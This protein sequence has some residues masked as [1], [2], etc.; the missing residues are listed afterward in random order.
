MM[1]A[2][3]LIFLIHFLFSGIPGP[4]IPEESSALPIEEYPQGYFSFP[5]SPGVTTSLSGSFGDIRINHFHAGLDI[6][7][8]GQEGKSIYSAGPGYVSRIKVSTGGYGNAL[9][10][11][12]PNG[13]TTVYGHLKEYAHE[14][15][16]YL[17][18]RQYDKQTWEIDLELKPDEIPVKKGELVAIS[19]NTG[20][21]GGPHLH[22]E[23]RD[24]EENTLDPALFGFKEI[25]DNVAPA[26]EYIS[27]KCM[28]DDARINGQ[29]GDFDFP[30]V[31][32]AEGNYSLPKELQLWGDIGLEIYT[33]DK[34]QTSPFKLGIKKLEIQ[35]NEL[36]T[37]YYHL[38]KLA[39]HNKIDCNLHTNYRRMVESNDKLHKGYFETGNSMELYEYDRNLGVLNCREAGESTLINIKLSDSYNNER[40]VN[41]RFQVK[42]EQSGAVPNLL[43]K[44]D[45]YKVFLFDTQL[46][47]I[48]LKQNG[49][50]VLWNTQG[51]KQV[52]PAYSNAREETFVFDL[53]SGFF[54]HFLH[55]GAKVKLPVTHRI[56]P[57]EREINENAYEIDF[58]N[59][60]F[61]P[62]FVNIENTGRKLILDKDDKPL[63]ESFYV[64]WKPQ[65]GGI[66]EEKDKVYNVA[67]K[68][69]KY[70]GGTWKGDHVTFRPKEFG[71]YE[72]LRDETPPT[73]EIRKISASELVF[74][75]SDTLSGIASFECLVNGEWVLMEYEYKN[76]LLW[77]E[78]K[79]STPFSGEVEL[80][81]TDQC[82]NTKTIKAT[83]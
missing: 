9:Y 75:I 82:N 32:S 78:K 2:F 44:Y 64:K 40:L 33:Y 52:T 7:T 74:R 66:L 65:T 42:K 21:S 16:K 24:A 41:F 51:E 5:L 45:E 13:Y 36:I 63:R 39:F 28:S 70:T 72:V 73:I 55:K 54:T 50:L 18:Q 4:S 30:V 57:E 77:S 1:S 22:F 60:L 47:L 81:V 38:D 25:K 29:F 68:K 19:G 31:L 8:G 34:A 59:T 10:I 69:P 6:R 58:Q 46:K 48:R 35:K 76:G 61:H 23:I 79:D 56:S 12:H 17:T 37:F 80:R 3:R 62:L 49:S 15:K 27:L 20:G 11:T 53:R 83:I 26:V 67:G 14:I 43:G 71:T